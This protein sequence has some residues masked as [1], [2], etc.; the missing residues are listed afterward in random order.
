LV[1]PVRDITVALIV[2]MFQVEVLN[3]RKLDLDLHSLKEP[4]RFIAR[5]GQAYGRLAAQLNRP[6][7]QRKALRTLAEQYNWKAQTCAEDSL[8]EIWLYSSGNKAVLFH[9]TSADGLASLEH[10]SVLIT[11]RIGKKANIKVA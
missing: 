9:W 11:N 6:E 8:R 4:C 3:W 2:V 7:P 10:V 5:Q 1:A